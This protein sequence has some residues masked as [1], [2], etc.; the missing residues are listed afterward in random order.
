MG[1]TS[2]KDSGVNLEGTVSS[3]IEVGR[4]DTLCRD[5][6]L[7]RA[8]EFLRPQLSFDD[9]RLLQRMQVEMASLPNKIRNAMESGQWRQVQELSEK[10]RMMTA[11]ADRKR[12]LQNLGKAVYEG[13]EIPIDPFSPGMQVLAGTTPRAL[14]EL[15]QKGVKLLEVLTSSDAPWQEFY[16]A[17][18]A[19]LKAL[20]ISAESTEEEAVTQPTAANLQ[21]EAMEALESGN[22]AKLQQVAGS[23]AEGA[24]IAAGGVAGTGIGEGRGAAAPPPDLDCTFPETGVKRARELG[25]VPERVESRYREVAHLL[26]FAWHPTFTHYETDQS[27]AMR[28]SGLPLAA[29]TPEALKGRIELF[30]L[31]PFVNS[32]GVRTLPKLTGEDLLVEDFDDPADGG[33]APRTALLEVLGLPRR[34]GLSRLQLEQALTLRGITVVRD[35]L[36]LDPAR[37]RLVCI[38]PDVHLRI[39]LK[40]DWGKQKL[41]THFDGYMVKPD[42]KLLALAGGDARFGG[43]YDMVGIGRNYDSDRIIARFAVVQRRRMALS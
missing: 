7:Q 28:V 16:A 19:A 29:D 1:K 21:H 34:N 25:L 11:D 42:G 41:W 22:F 38:P 37:F 5:L 20:V 32:A 40:R 26:S 14:P 2:A 13:E 39:G 18:L 43:V 30:A 8:A 9:Y 10:H 27:G 33:D 24:P 23:L 6:Y 4:I 35:E 31:H 17:R 3:L 15:R 36:G 12:L